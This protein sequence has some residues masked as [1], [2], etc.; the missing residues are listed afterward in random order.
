MRDELATVYRLASVVS[1]I[2]DA[3]D[4]NTTIASIRVGEKYHSMKE[5]IHIIV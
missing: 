4:G 5:V 2:Q 1:S 3:A